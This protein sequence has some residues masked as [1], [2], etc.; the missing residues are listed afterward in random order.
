MGRF[1]PATHLLHIWPLPAGSRHMLLLVLRT[2]CDRVKFQ[3]RSRRLGRLGHMPNIPEAELDLNPSWPCS[4]VGAISSSCALSG[5]PPACHIQ[6]Y[7]RVHHILSIHTIL[8]LG[9]RSK[10]DALSNSQRWLNVKNLTLFPK[11]TGCSV[12]LSFYLP[13]PSHVLPGPVCTAAVCS[14]LA[15]PAPP[16]L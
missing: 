4:K 2:S 1:P 9:P 7:S 5:R 14:L 16:H 15:R 8:P 11:G 6:S 10:T 12:Q 3:Q 13:W